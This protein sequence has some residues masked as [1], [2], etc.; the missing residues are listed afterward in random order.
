MP[1]ADPR[2]GCLSRSSGSSN[3]LRSARII[4]LS[5]DQSQ[6]FVTPRAEGKTDQMRLSR[7]RV[8]FPSRKTIQEDRGME[9]R[10]ERESMTR[11]KAMLCM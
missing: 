3:R 7:E 2:R 8:V 9:S 4:L 1:V 11:Q 6:R 10:T 5:L